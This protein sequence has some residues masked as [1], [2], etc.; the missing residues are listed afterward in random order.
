MVVV[1]VAGAA[2]RTCAE[3]S[4]LQEREPEGSEEEDDEEGKRPSK[5]TIGG[6]WMPMGETTPSLLLEEA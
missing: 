4:G 5:T 2:A 3:L 6:S 1:V